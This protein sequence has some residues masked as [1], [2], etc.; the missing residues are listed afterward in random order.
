MWWRGLG[1]V[2][3]FERADGL[4]GVIFDVGNEYGLN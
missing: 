4:S 2:L 1:T 3:G